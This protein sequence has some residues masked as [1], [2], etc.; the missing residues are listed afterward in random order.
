[1]ATTDTD[2]SSNYRGELYLI[3]NY[4]T[5]FLSMIG[6]LNVGKRSQS[7]AFPLAQPYSVSSAS[8]NVQSEDTSASAGTATTYTR[9]EDTNTCQIMKYDAAVTFK[10]QSQF[11]LMAGINTNHDNPVNNELMF[12][13]QA[14]LTQMAIDVEYSF[15]NGS[16]QAASDSSTAAQTRG[17]VTACS[18]N[19]VAAGSATLTKDIVDE[20]LR[21]MAGNGA[22][23]R[24][25]VLFCNAFQK[26]KI[27]D[28]YGYA[29]DDRNIGG[30]N[31]KTIET[32]FAQMG[33]MY[34]NY[35]DTDEILI[36]DLAFCSPVFVPVMFDGEDFVVDMVGGSDVLWVPTAVTAAQ[37]G[38][39]YY[40]QIGLDYGPEEYHGSIT[41]L[42]TS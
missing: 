18:S 29:P 28:I 7:F 24:N 15:L 3:G 27:S 22:K 9:A 30:V 35:M 26:Q 10:R 23:F 2:T 34:D 21:E 39:F 25:P 6:G 14:A 32:D 11:G 37:K 19:T 41:G 31:I 16:Y 13:K 8:Q 12:Q 5:P 33:I 40:T 17:I 4:D 20:L 1:M 36:A 38:G 42:A